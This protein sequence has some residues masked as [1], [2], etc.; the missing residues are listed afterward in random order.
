MA[1]GVANAACVVAFLTQ[2]YEE[3]SNCKL[4]HGR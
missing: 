4:S 1:E 2:K 3:S